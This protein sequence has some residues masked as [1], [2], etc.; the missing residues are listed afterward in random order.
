VLLV[1]AHSATVK[2]LQYRVRR[3]PSYR[4]AGIGRTSIP[5]AAQLP[6]MTPFSLRVL[7]A[8]HPFLLYIPLN[9]PLPRLARRLSRR[10]PPS[11]PF[12]TH[13]KVVP[14]R[15]THLHFLRWIILPCHSIARTH[16]WDTH[17]RHY[18]E[19]R[20]TQVR[21]I[22]GHLHLV[23]VRVNSRIAQR[24][25]RDMYLAALD[26]HIL[27][28]SFIA[29]TLGAI[30]GMALTFRHPRL[31]FHPFQTCSRDFHKVKVRRC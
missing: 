31:P 7:R 14:R 27:V 6:L 25:P 9:P 8:R 30:T 22:L 11:P 2:N 13:S 23:P 28:L 12:A 21:P 15:T 3:P 10:S 1:L 17:H 16:H 29:Q 26:T 20:K 19:D 4:N 18:V 24:V 5:E